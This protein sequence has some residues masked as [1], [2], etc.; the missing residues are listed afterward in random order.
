MPRRKINISLTL[1]QYKNRLQRELSDEDFS[2]L[3]N[4]ILSSFDVYSTWTDILPEGHMLDCYVAV[5]HREAIRRGFRPIGITSER[6]TRGM[7]ICNDFGNG[8][9]RENT[10]VVYCGKF[11]Y[12]SGHDKSIF[13]PI[14]EDYIYE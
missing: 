13:A 10:K 14:K 11:S 8:R 4:A 1:Q 6:K 5:V 2:Q 7:F 9:T 3:D 12:F